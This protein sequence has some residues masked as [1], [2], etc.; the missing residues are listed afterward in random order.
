MSINHIMITKSHMNSIFLFFSEKVSKPVIF[1][2][3][4]NRT[5]TCEVTKGTDFKLRLYHNGRNVRE[6]QTVVT[7][8][9]DAKP[10][11]SF[12][13][14][15]NNSVS[16]ETSKAVVEC[17]GAWRAPVRPTSPAHLTNTARQAHGRGRLHGR[18]PWARRQPRL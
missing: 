12:T 5:L 6:G 16:E 2:S 8:R 18:G 13:C 3:C 11:G 1:W 10:N 9:W 15:A 17:P 4:I 7:Y 14:V